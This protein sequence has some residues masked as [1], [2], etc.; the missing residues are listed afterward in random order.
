[1]TEYDDEDGESEIDH[2]VE[3]YLDGSITVEYFMSLSNFECW[4]S[5]SKSV[6]E[7]IRLCSQA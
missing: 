1:M 3:D 5:S 7:C 6:R 2:L 4:L